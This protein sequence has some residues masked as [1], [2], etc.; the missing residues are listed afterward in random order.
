MKRLQVPACLEILH[1]E[2]TGESVAIVVHCRSNEDRQV[3]A[4]NAS[5]PQITHVRKCCPR[6][7]AFDRRTRICV[8]QSH[9]PLSLLTLLPNESVD[10]DHVVIT[11][12]GSPKCEGP[13][14]DYEI[15]VDDVFTWNGT[16]SVSERR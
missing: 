13:I 15:D 10:E 2:T 14:V 6:D 3:K 7:A 4:I 12:E 9:N 11:T 1:N 5:F 8:S 16:Y